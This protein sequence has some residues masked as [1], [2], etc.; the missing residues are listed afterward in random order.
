MWFIITCIAGFEKWIMYS[1]LKFANFLLSKGELKFM[2]F[3]IAKA[4]QNDTTNIV[5]KS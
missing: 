4:T 3:G 5:Q 1:N 2:D